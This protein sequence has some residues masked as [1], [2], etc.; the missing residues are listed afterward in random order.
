MKRTRNKL[1]RFTPKITQED[2]EW[3]LKNRELPF[4]DIEYQIKK[5]IK[6]RG[7]EISSRTGEYIYKV[8]EDVLR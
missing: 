3:M 5:R 7:H 2:K 6:S 4:E 1:G 8:F